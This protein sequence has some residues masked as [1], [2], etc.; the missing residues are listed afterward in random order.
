MILCKRRIPH[1]ICSVNPVKRMKTMMQINT[2]P[3]PD[4]RSNEIHVKIDQAESTVSLTYQL[5]N[6]FHTM[7]RSYDECLEKTL[8]RFSITCR[9]KLSKSSNKA[10]RVKSKGKGTVSD[11]SMEH[12]SEPDKPLH[13]MVTF[14]SIVCDTAAMKNNELKTGMC[15]S[16]DDQVYRVVVN[17]PTVLSLSTYPKSL[18]YAGCPIVPQVGIEFGDDFECI[19]ACETSAGS[20]EYVTACFDKVFTPTDSVVGCRVKLFCTAVNS[21]CDAA[22]EVRTGRSV[23]FYLSGAVQPSIVSGR[24]FNRMLEV[25]RDFCNVSRVRSGERPTSGFSC[26]DDQID[27]EGSTR[28]YRGPDELRAITYN[29]LAEPFAT[30]E[31]AYVTLYPYCDPQHLQSEYRIQRVLAELLACDAD[32][33]CLQEC[34][35]RSFE[36]Y[37]LP[38][39]GRLGYAGHF[40]CKGSTEGCATF[41]YNATCRVVQRV[42]LPLKNVLRE[43]SF[44]TRLYELRPDLRDVI[45]GKLGTVAQ[46][47]VLQSLHRPNQALVVANTHL[48]YH[49]LAS[50]L[51]VIQV[52]AITQALSMMQESIESEAG[53]GLQGD[54]IQLVGAEET[55]VFGDEKE[56]RLANSLLDPQVVRQA[57][58][59][60]EREAV[61]AKNSPAGPCKATVMLLGDLNSSPNIAA[62]QFLVK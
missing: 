43:A 34:D 40:T 28:S 12:A 56:S 46:I 39:M 27:V 48:F 47:T 32:V 35:L 53:A 17:P 59:N 18:I 61:A 42:D 5:L 30:S 38:L 14:Q 37:L 24:D 22:S 29:I 49:P 11:V 44:L 7:N 4:F 33:V 1:I 62:M 2:T 36:A 20:N 55:N 8:H 57:E 10:K 26:L 9:T 25:R 52:Y 19:W 50:F 60:C 41:T 23:V 54:F 45:G 16:L 15:I 31:Q 13:P 51:R 21:D 58:L 6:E 3:Q